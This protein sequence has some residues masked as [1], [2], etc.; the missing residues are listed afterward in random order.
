MWA[1]DMEW[2][3]TGETLYPFLNRDN[4]AAWLWFNG[5]TNPRWFFNFSKAEWEWWP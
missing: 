2:V 5:A 1:S 3:Y 4:D